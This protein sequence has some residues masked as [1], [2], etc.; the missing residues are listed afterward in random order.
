MTKALKDCGSMSKIRKQAEK[1]P[2]LKKVWA[3]SVAPLKS[4]IESCFSHL[5]LK[6]QPINVDDPVSE[7]D[8]NILMRHLLEMFPD[9][10]VTKL[11]KAHTRKSVSYN[12]WKEKHCRER[13][14]TFQIRKCNNP[15]CCSPATLSPEILRWLPDPLLTESGEHSEVNNIK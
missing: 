1:T 8:I 10:D 7:E 4:I 15:D 12:M 14:Y 6:G 5:K 9:L 3:D 2:E 11:Q 13:K